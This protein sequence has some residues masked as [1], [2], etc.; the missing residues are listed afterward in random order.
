MNNASTS[1]FPPLSPRLQAV[2][3]AVLLGAAAADIGTD[4]A[5][6]PAYLRLHARSPRVLACDCRPGPLTAA[7]RTLAR[8][9]ITQVELRHGNGLRVLT[10]G[11]VSTA[12]LAGMGGHRIIQ[13]LD[14]AP[15]QTACLQ[16][17]VLQPNSEWTWCRRAI[18]RR[19]WAWVDEVLVQEGKH[20]YLVLVVDPRLRPDPLGLAEEDFE[21]G[22]TLRR[23]PTPAYR[24]WLADV[25]G[26]LE[27]TRA[28][29][30]ARVS[31]DHPRRH[32]L[33]ARQRFYEAALRTAE[34]A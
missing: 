4:H 10:P 24:A 30:A 11:E 5:L 8:W 12:I 17:L 15:A 34:E 33:M 7:A 23:T 3:D 25:I 21:L 18:A 14:D 32:A 9:G 1:A 2:A 20:F 16:R 27:H 13:I 29:L 22:P 28:Q 19:G 6:V 26:R 31:A